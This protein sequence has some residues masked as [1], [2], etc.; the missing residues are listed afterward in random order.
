MPDATTLPTPKESPQDVQDIL[1]AMG[2]TSAQMAVRTNTPAD[3]MPAEI[4]AEPTPEPAPVQ[5][6][7]EDELGE[8]ADAMLRKAGADPSAMAAVMPPPKPESIEALDQHLAEAVDSLLEN[9][10]RANPLPAAEASALNVPP[11]RAAEPTTSNV[12]TAPAPVAAVAAVPETPPAP[13]PE[14][15]APVAPAP[16]QPPPAAAPKV[17]TPPAPPPPAPMPRPAAVAAKAPAPAST[18]GAAA[19]ASKS[20]ASKVASVATSVG[21]QSQSILSAI[22][23]PAL[24]A[25]AAISKPIAGKS[26]FVR[27]LVGAAALVTLFW[28][29][30]FWLYA[31]IWQPPV[32]PSTPKPPEA[33]AAGHG[34][35]DDGHGAKKDDGHGAKKDDGHGAKKTAKADKKSSSKK[36]ASAD[37][38]GGGH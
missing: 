6:G 31:L 23:P 10:R 21:K 22:E 17:S 36:K 28:A 7:A 29:V 18:N 24:Q 20:K 26:K 14:A 13:K 1:G 19:D 25:A 32:G 12:E 30:C 15:P 16:T 35:G 9:E 27:D 11:P 38:H 3:P 8:A 33:A 2:V 4:E 5:A 34:G 37:S